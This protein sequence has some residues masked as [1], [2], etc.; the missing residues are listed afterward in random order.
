MLHS[1]KKFRE[2]FRFFE[3][4]SFLFFLEEYLN[5]QHLLRAC[6]EKACRKQIVGLQSGSFEFFSPFSSK[7]KLAGARPETDLNGFRAPPK[8]SV[9][10]FTKMYL[11][12]NKTALCKN[13][14]FIKILRYTYCKLIK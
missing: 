4:L 8:S 5:R 6:E 11:E 2:L 10:L 12:K 7:A 9:L 14:F 13:L 1:K 3:R